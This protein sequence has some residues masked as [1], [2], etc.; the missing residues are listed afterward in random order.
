MKKD[1]AALNHMN[2]HKIYIKNIC[3]KYEQTQPNMRKWCV[4]T[5]WNISVINTKNVPKWIS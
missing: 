3:K 2:K 5:P 1:V 4:V